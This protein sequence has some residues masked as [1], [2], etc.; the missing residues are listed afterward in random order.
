M[1]LNTHSTA[2]LYALTCLACVI[3]LAQSLMQAQ[4]DGSLLDWSTIVFSLCLLVVIGWCARCAVVGWN[5]KDGD[6]AATSH[7]AGPR[8]SIVDDM[9]IVKRGGGRR[10]AEIAS[11]RGMACTLARYERNERFPSIG[12]GPDPHRAAEPRRR[13]REP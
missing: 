9:S 10:L 8:R 5:T 6:Q 12:H 1:R 2:R 3:W 11:E 4:A 13:T 7:D